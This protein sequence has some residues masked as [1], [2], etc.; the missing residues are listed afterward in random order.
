MDRKQLWQAGIGLSVGMVLAAAVTGLVQGQDGPAREQE[1]PPAVQERRAPSPSRRQLRLQ[2]RALMEVNRDP[3]TAITPDQAKQLL[4]VLKPWTT[5]GKMT[6]EESRTIL[7]SVQQVM[8]PRQLSAMAQVR[9][10]RGRGFRGPGGPEGRPDQFRGP[11]GPEGP[12][13]RRGEGGPPPFDPARMSAMRDAN[14]LSTQVDPDMPWGSRR[15]EA[16]QRLIAM[17]E[18]RAR[19]GGTSAA[20]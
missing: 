17:L 4:A 1:R 14:I 10:Q 5:K 6:E 16:N 12:R 20:S 2:L 9:P 18:D 11:G 19:G 7:R 15:A 3:A 13:R 8:T